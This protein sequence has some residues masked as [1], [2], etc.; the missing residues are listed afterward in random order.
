M[1]EI[2]VTMPDALYNELFVLEVDTFNPETA[3]DGRMEFV[4]AMQS[5]KE[6]KR[7]YKLTL[8]PAG[9]EYMLKPTGALF[10]WDDTW[11]DRSQD[12]F[13]PEERKEGRRLRSQAKRMA[14]KVKKTLAKPAGNPG[15]KKL[16]KKAAIKRKE[17]E[18]G[19][20]PEIPRGTK[21]SLQLERKTRYASSGTGSARVTRKVVTIRRPIR[22]WDYSVEDAQGRIYALTFRQGQPV[23]LSGPKADYHVLSA[24]PL[25]EE[26]PS[27]SGFSTLVQRLKF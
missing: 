12:E 1:A 25:P 23:H 10:A 13:D 17:K 18:M 7:G 15:R 9:A 4:E 26:N 6:M 14:E 2:T 5:A 16:S 11:E 22:K 21:M 19:K 3:Q 20:R 24:N 27:N 8:D